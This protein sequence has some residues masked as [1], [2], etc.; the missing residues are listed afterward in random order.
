VLHRDLKP[1]N[2]VLGDFGEVVLLDW[3]LAKIIGQPEAPGGPPSPAPPPDGSRDMTLQ[4]Q[5][6][7]TPAYMAPE[8]AA[9]RPDRVGERSDVYG[10]GAILYEI[11]TGR[12]PFAGENTHALLQKVV[13]EE[14]AAPRQRVP[15]T[16][17]ALEAVCLKALTKDPAGRY[18]SAKE[19]AQDVERWLAD[20]PVT[21]CR[22]PWRARLG[23]WRR[24]HP[25][26]VGALAVLVLAAAGVGVWV[27]QERDARA[28]DA[29][30]RE[31]AGMA[32]LEEAMLRQN[33][34]QWADARAAVARAEVRLAGNAPPSLADRLRQARANLDMVAVL[35][36]IPLQR[37]Q[38]QGTGFNAAVADQA[39]T[40]AFE[41]YGL[42]IMDLDPRAAAGQLTAS[43]IFELLVAALY[44]WIESIPGEQADR[45]DHL[46]AVLEATDNDPWRRR[47][48]RLLA[49]PDRAA[50]EALAR[51][52]AV[53]LQPPATRV[54]FAKALRRANAV[55]AAADLLQQAQQQYPADFWINHN[56]GLY[57]IELQPPHADE[58][59]GY[60]RAA[61]AL[62]P[63][64]SLAHGNLGY[65]LGRLGKL[66]EAEAEY[67]KVLALQPTNALAYV[68]L[69]GNLLNQHRFDEAEK[70]VRRA[71][72]LEPKNPVIHFDLGEVLK[73][74]GRYG[75]ALAAYKRGHQVTPPNSP[76]YAA[77]QQ[78]VKNAQ[79]QAAL[80]ERLPGVREGK[81]QPASAQ[82]RILFAEM[83]LQGPRH[84]PA[85]AAR[86][87]REAFTA[88]PSLAQ[89][90]SAARLYN[91]ACAA[92]RA[93]GGKGEDAARLDAA[94][95]QH[96]RQQALDWL[97]DDLAQWTRRAESGKAE[98]RA[99]LR[100]ALTRWQQEEDLSPLR[101]PAALAALPATQRAAC[102]KLWQDVAALLQQCAA[103]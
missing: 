47:L 93:A 17:A 67:R 23:R 89:D 11:L 51:D 78:W 91:A 22:E 59:V 37:A 68:N 18:A 21:A 53:L 95:R 45:R 64:S 77:S 7:G 15:S 84:Y 16:P 54:L 3:G 80:A 60:L 50:L 26:L 65:L 82:E 70:A 2:V 57:L 100:Q 25:A 87:Y 8:Q 92:A 13:Q 19:L 35:E 12:P 79:Q 98:D 72:S 90:L 5:V 103:P 32:D 85:A 14:P 62:R 9:G 101:A 43:T 81:T 63:Q 20:E 44:D 102:Q 1:K 36:D 76:W 99:A 40:K 27:K 71:V 88:E 38:V 41:R 66:A 33:N 86:L 49:Q 61:L 96:W 46:L 6:L 29:A 75:E 28:V 4:G 39:Y 55:Q 94:G 30:R 74:Q 97:R 10:L 56:L 24:R 48:R 58:A 83:C 52:A 42:P 34:G 73:Q 69:G 31:A